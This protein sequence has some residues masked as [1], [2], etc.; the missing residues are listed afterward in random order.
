VRFWQQGR[1]NADQLHMDYESQ[2]ARV[3]LDADSDDSKELGL[4]FI[5]VDATTDAG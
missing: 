1:L 4:P 2:L 5:L 3:A